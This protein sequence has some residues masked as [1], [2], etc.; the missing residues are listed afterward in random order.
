MLLKCP[1]SGLFSGRV[2]LR[3]CVRDAAKSSDNRYITDNPP[4]N[5]RVDGDPLP[6]NRAITREPD[7]SDALKEFPELSE[8]LKES[9]GIA[10]RVCDAALLRHPESPDTVIPRVYAR[11]AAWLVVRQIPPDLFCIASCR[12]CCLY[13]LYGGGHARISQLQNW[14]RPVCWRLCSVA[15]NGGICPAQLRPAACLI[16]VLP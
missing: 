6:E 4:E 5:R 15:I 11:D 12:Y 9:K 3:A 7:I 16:H 14:T 13:G 8:A 2:I 1:D 10:P